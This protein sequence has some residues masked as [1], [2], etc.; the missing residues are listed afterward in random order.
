MGEIMDEKAIVRKLMKMKG[1]NQKLIAENAGFK[2]Q[3]NVAEKFRSK[4]MRVDNLIR[5]LDAMDCELVIRSKTSI[6]R[7]DDPGRMH[8]PEFVVEVDRDWE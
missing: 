6:P 7:A 1:Y 5:I 4:S 2:H 3:S 8:K